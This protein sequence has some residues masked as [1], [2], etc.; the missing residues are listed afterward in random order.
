[1][2]STRL[3]E[4]ARLC[5]GR[6]ERAPGAERITGV[7]IDS[8]RVGTEDLFVAIGLGVD[9]VN[10]ALGRGAAA[11]LVPEDPH[12]AMAAL[13][14]I[15]R[16]AVRAR[17]VGIT[18]ATGKTTTKDILAALCR[19]HARTVAA[20]QSHNNEIGLPLTLTRANEGTEIVIAELGTRGMG[21]VR[22]LSRIARPHIALIAQIGPAHLEMFG[23][24]ERV[25]EAEAEIV[26]ELPAGG[27]VIAP[28]GEPLLAP[29]LRRQDV[30]VVTYGDRG[31]VALVDFVV[32]DHGHLTA[33]VAGERV[34][35]TLPFRARHN[36]TNALGA[37]AAYRALGLPLAE[38]GRGAMDVV[39]SRW[40]EEEV[41][42]PGG[43]LL[44]ND[45]YN[46]NPVSMA[47]ALQHLAERA[48]GRRR[49][50]VLGEMAELGGGTAAYHRDVGRRAAAEGVD[51]IVGVGEQARWYLEGAPDV[52]QRVWAATA[53]DAVPLVRRH[54]RDGDCVLVKGSR[55]VGL[56][57][58]VDALTAGA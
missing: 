47:A 49:L 22:E 19:P 38:V 16:D 53:A 43:G 14:R 33:D 46:A 10:D 11:A 58:V 50:A 54:L 2:I 20:E 6:L 8:R 15:A 57:A 45:C 42:L 29:H 23:T 37:L 34:E 36:A 18:G 13:G 17:V 51:V 7:E 30:E 24:V 31:D 21:Q 44:V 28:A 41:P 4:V 27:V 25:A 35:L 56:E 52:E 9:H 48:N 26:G 39:L 1:V 5:A 3:D 40:R 12:A 55:S 32:R